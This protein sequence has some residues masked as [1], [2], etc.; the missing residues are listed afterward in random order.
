M[1]VGAHPSY[2]DRVGFGRRQLEMNRDRL[3]NSI[4]DQILS[5]KEIADLEGVELHHIKPHGALYNAASVYR[6]IAKTVAEA[7]KELSLNVIV[8]GQSGSEFEKAALKNGLKFCAEVFADRAY[9]DDLRLRFRREEGAVLHKR[10]K[11]CLR[12]LK[13]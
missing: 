2:P 11:F 13:W 12:F 9:E 6:D 5:L 4:K 10:K 3:K 1:K 7:I 8:Y